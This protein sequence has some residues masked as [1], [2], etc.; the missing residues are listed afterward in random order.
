MANV[1][2]PQKPGQVA[3]R[4]IG[5]SIATPG[6]GQELTRLAQAT[7]S[8]SFQRLGGTVHVTPKSPTAP[9]LDLRGALGQVDSSVGPIVGG[10]TRSLRSASNTASDLAGTVSRGL[11]LI[12]PTGAESFARG[13]GLIINGSPTGIAAAINSTARSFNLSLAGLVKLLPPGENFSIILRSPLSYSDPNG[14]TLYFPAGSR[15]LAKDGYLTI[16]AQGASIKAGEIEF[17]AG[18]ARLVV[19]PRENL[20]RFDRLY[21]KTGSG[22]L[23]VQDVTARMQPDGATNA[24]AGTIEVDLTTGSLRA[25]DVILDAP[26]A[27][28]VS[29]TADSVAFRNNDVALSTGATSLSQTTLSNGVTTTNA[30]AKALDFARGSQRL[31][32]DSMLLDLTRG[33]NGEGGLRWLATDVKFSDGTN[34]LN[35]ASAT[36]GFTQRA[37]GSTMHLQTRD[38][39]LALGNHG[40]VRATGNALFDLRYRDGKLTDVTARATSVEFTDSATNLKAAGPRLEARFNAAGRL[41]HLNGGVDPLYLR[42]R[43]GSELNVKGTVGITQEGDTTLLGVHVNEGSY[44]NDW[45]TFTLGSS[46]LDMSISPETI[47]FVGSTEK[48]MFT[49]NR[50]DTALAFTDGRVN[51]LFGQKV[52]D[53]VSITG[54]SARY[55]GT[56]ATNVFTGF[57][58]ENVKADLTRDASGVSTLTMA[59]NHVGMRVGD[60]R[61]ALE[62]AQNVFVTDSNGRVAKIDVRFLGKAS[63]RAPNGETVTGSNIAALYSDDTIRGSFDTAGFMLP[64]LGLK[65]EFVDGRGVVNPDRIAG[66]VARGYVEQTTNTPF[67]VTFSNLEFNATVGHANLVKG[68]QASV[69]NLEGHYGLMNSFRLN[70]PTQLRYDGK[71]TL[72]LSSREFEGEARVNGLRVIGAGRVADIGLSNGSIFFERIG[73]TRA[74]VSGQGFDVTADINDIQGVVAQFDGVSHGATHSAAFTLTPSAADAF[75]NVTASFKVMA[76]VP[77]SLDVENAPILKAHGFVEPNRVGV[78]IDT[79]GGGN[80]VFDAGGVLKLHGS[81]ISATGTYEPL[82]V[83]RFTWAIANHLRRVNENLFVSDKGSIAFE[84]PGP[85]V[86]GIQFDFPYNYREVPPFVDNPST[87]GFSVYGGGQSKDPEGRT[88]A[89]LKVGASA[90]GSA[91]TLDVQR[92]EASLFGVPVPQRLSLP[93]TAVF[94]FF[95]RREVNDAGTTNATPMT[96]SATGGVF[97]NPAAYVSEKFVKEETKYGLYGSGEV[98]HGDST[99][100]IG[101]TMTDDGKFGV[102]GSVGFKF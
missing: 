53:F 65:G 37:D 45:G 1:N 33:A 69:S 81:D 101:A 59:S 48:F 77:L 95:F 47:G 16:V 56:S 71:D 29:A 58:A 5:S 8:D 50:G 67:A 38:G 66:S 2:Q 22:S 68:A 63:L 73:D 13:L 84:V 21:G 72:N 34:R 96:I 94:G 80:V 40:D 76:G 91:L 86:V 55:S 88:T 23:D 75:S 74:G 62:N 44:I 52:G 43:D 11:N 102:V 64:N 32:A 98:Q 24:R 14:I 28:S 100:S 19:G 89:G 46:A 4:E 31:T 99:F 79:Q 12:S 54:R 49:E 70:G 93:T 83:S 42:L 9:I 90:G 85:V 20:V 87:F 82:N 78:M 10:A 7:N 17:D 41:T 26:N 3:L 97:G 18:Q 61:L 39:Q 51:A 35:L 57:E 25:T 30:S 60:Y 36:L 15:V 6:A 27:N 92:G